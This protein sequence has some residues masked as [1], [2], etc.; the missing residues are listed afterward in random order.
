MRAISRGYENQ[1]PHNMDLKSQVSVSVSLN[2]SNPVSV[3]TSPLPQCPQDLFSKY[4]LVGN[5]VLVHIPLEF[6][7][8]TL[9]TNLLVAYLEIPKACF[10][11]SR[12][13]RKKSP[14]LKCNF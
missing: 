4:L 2:L 8:V 12:R 6:Y 11:N 14:A 5:A 7:L 1:L 13:R 3:S 10:F 9:V